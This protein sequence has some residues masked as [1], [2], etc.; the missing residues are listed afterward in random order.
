MEEATE[1]KE[2]A[3]CIFFR[4]ES[5]NDSDGI[6]TK[7]DRNVPKLPT[8]GTDCNFFINKQDF[9]EFSEYADD[10]DDFIV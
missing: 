5:V 9:W 3:N 10:D 7:N 2:C 4:S 6:C 8:D 1:I